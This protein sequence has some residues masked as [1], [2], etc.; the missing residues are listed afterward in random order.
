MKIQI[1]LGFLFI[2]HLSAN[3]YP[4][5][6]EDAIK[7]RY[8]GRIDDA[9]S[10]IQSIEGGLLPEVEVILAKLYLDK[11]MY[12]EAIKYYEKNCKS[13]DTYECFNEYAISL[14]ENQNYEEAI[15]N[16][17]KSISLNPSFANGF[18]NLAICYAKSKDYIKAEENHLKALEM[19]PNN[20]VIRINYGIFLLKLKKYQRAKDILYPVISENEAMY[21]AELYIGIAH[22]Q[23]E[24]YNAALIHYNRAISISP[25][26][27]ELYYH[28]ALLYYKRGDYHGALKDLQFYEKL[29]GNHPKVNDLKKLIKLN[30]R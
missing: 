3:L 10:K 28:R 1:I 24:E 5:E 11:G 17:E 2:L 25:E 22:Y 30:N 15:I 27:P 12:T 14:M 26:Y 16:F 19:M 20:P 18:S 7:L 4:K 8:Q 9:I 21:F 23:K 6:V 13:L 29:N